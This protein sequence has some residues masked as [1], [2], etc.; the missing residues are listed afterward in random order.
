MQKGNDQSVADRLRKTYYACVRFIRLQEVFAES[1][2]VFAADIDAII[3]NNIFDKNDFSLFWFSSPSFATIEDNKIYHN[4]F[5]KPADA[6]SST[7]ALSG[8]AIAVDYYAAVN[9]NIYNNNII[10]DPL[11]TYA[12]VFE[13][14]GGSVTGNTFK[15]NIIYDTANLRLRYAGTTYTTVAA[16]EAGMP[17]VFIPGNV[18][19]NPT[20]TDPEND[21]FSLAIGSPG[22]ATASFLATIQTGGISGT[23]PATF[24]LGTNE[25]YAFAP[26]DW[27]VPNFDGDFVY[28]QN[29]T[30]ARVT[31]RTAN[32]ITVDSATGFS[33][34]DTLTV[35]P[36]T[37]SAPDIGLVTSDSSPPG[38]APIYTGWFNN[39]GTPTT[40]PSSHVPMAAD[41]TYL[42]KITATSAGTAYSVRVF[43]DYV[44]DGT[45]W[46]VV[47][48]MNGTTLEL[49][50]YAA[51]TS[52]TLNTWTSELILQEPASEDMSFSSSDDLYFG[53]AGD[54]TSAQSIAIGREDTGGTGL[55]WSTKAFSGAPHAELLASDMATPVA[56]RDM[57]FVLGYTIADDTGDPVVTITSP[58]SDATYNS[59]AGVNTI[60]LSGTSSD[61]ASYVTSITWADNHGNSGSGSIADPWTTWSIDDLVLAAGSTEITVTATDAYENTSTDTITVTF[62]GPT[63]TL[64]GWDYEDNPPDD[65][66]T[67]SA[68]ETADRIY[69]STPWTAPAGGGDIAGMYWYVGDTWT[70]TRA[71][72]V[73]YRVSGSQYVQIAETEITSAALSSYNY[74]AF[75]APVSGQSLRFAENDQI[76]FGIAFDVGSGIKYGRNTTGGSGLLFYEG[77][78][79]EGPIDLT[80]ATDIT[81]TASYAPGFTMVYTALPGDVT[82]P[83]I[84]ITSPSEA[85]SIVVSTYTIAGTAS[86]ET[87]LDYVVWSCSES[88]YGGTLSVSDGVWSS[89]IELTLG[90]NTIT[91]RAYDASGNY[92]EDTVVI[93]QILPSFSASGSFSN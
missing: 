80:I 27:G 38:E 77:D 62:V 41:R 39:S 53:I 37:G 1:T 58:T 30:R 76:L 23:A 68:L 6:G 72:A 57:A 10:Y 32:T 82:A 50:G 91:T 61:A 92:T 86:D 47:Y 52:P 34:G 4:V 16:A 43:I 24:T 55:Y 17:S 49:I 3:R 7:Q 84:S 42:R 56:G 40:D 29:G 71:W 65:T 73:A 46:A 67:S 21:D 89:L 60:S 2:T 48:K 69:L 54:P 87:E 45:A 44:F 51:I 63:G 33:A 78:L 59:S 18:A 8:S 31:G 25:G 88:E 83:S 90:D 20:F 35:M 28:N 13:N 66:V 19:T 74:A 93:T 75:S 12:I 5:Y 14:Q 9:R 81:T 15:K 26:S 36:F 79:T 11:G 22:L 64:V 85:I 70:P